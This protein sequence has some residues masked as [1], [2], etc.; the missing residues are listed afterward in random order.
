MNLPTNKLRDLIAALQTL[1]PDTITDIECV[2]AVDDS[3]QRVLKF[4]EDNSRPKE[5]ILESISDKLTTELFEPV[6]NT[7]DDWAAEI[8]RM[9]SEIEKLDTSLENLLEEH[10]NLSYR[11]NNVKEILASANNLLA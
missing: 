1:D 10:E 5:I 11:L 4:C 6:N 7:L 9:G 8:N 3:G 2:F